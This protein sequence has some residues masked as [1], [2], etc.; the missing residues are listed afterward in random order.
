MVN[1]CRIRER[2]QF[3]QWPLDRPGSF[4]KRI[5]FLE[6]AII[7]RKHE[8]KVGGEFWE[9]RTQVAKIFIP[10]HGSIFYLQNSSPQSRGPPS[11]SIP[12]KAQ[13][14][15]GQIC[16]PSP[17]KEGWP[18]H[19]NRTVS[20]T[21]GFCFWTQL[22]VFKESYLASLIRGYQHHVTATKT[23]SVELSR[24]TAWLVSRKSRFPFGLYRIFSKGL[25]KKKKKKQLTW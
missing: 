10:L 15:S 2:H 22:R 23:L 6:I 12:G 13:W 3:P 19:S 20:W 14:S 11:F 21:Q 16:A 24:E 7:D 1:F 8:R 25:F 4:R 18:V 5:A 9:N 17:G